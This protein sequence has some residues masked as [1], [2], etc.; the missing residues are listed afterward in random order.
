MTAD[1]SLAATPSGAGP[2][3]TGTAIVIGEKAVLIVGASRAGKSGL[4]ERLI[5]EAGQRGRFAMLVGD[6]RVAITVRGGRLVVAAH[7][8]VAGR[9][10][11]RGIGIVAAPA[12][13]EAVLG[14]VISL[15]PDP[16]RLPEAADRAVE[17]AGVRLPLMRL[18][19]DQD[20]SAKA[21]L[22]LAW[23]TP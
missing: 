22:A 21:H 9:I 16:P 12:L 3:A 20:L 18:R 10:E 2:Y 6:D 1:A 7:P 4:A 15:E 8:A 23:I 5:A 19:Q 11:R 17:I 13:A 14:A